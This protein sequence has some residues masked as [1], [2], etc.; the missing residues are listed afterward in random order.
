MYP[1]AEL[2]SINNN[3]EATGE[4]QRHRTTMRESE[5]E[6]KR[7]VDHH[8]S[9]CNEELALTQ[10]E[11]VIRRE[12]IHAPVIAKLFAALNAELSELYT[13]VGANHFELA[14]SDVEEGT[15]ALLVGWIGDEAV[16]CSAVRRL[17]NETAELKRMYVVPGAR[18]KGVALQLLRATEVEARRLSVTRLVLETGE[19]QPEA[20][21][22]AEKVGYV[23]I[24]P[25]GEYAGSP[26][27]VCMGRK[28]NE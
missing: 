25:F 17:G 14:A 16:G 6:A 3:N 20:I 21:A 1:L 4:L 12:S 2:L 13:E 9:T 8:V 26:L 18:G 24:A 11:L 10:S 19:R 27:S 23:R 5:P 15:G 22:L 28:L 7:A